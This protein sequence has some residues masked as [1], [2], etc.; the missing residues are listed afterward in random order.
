M[1]IYKTFDFI[2]QV[3]CYLNFVQLFVLF[4]LEI[5]EKS[6]KEQKTRDCKRRGMIV[7]LNQNVYSYVTFVP[8]RKI[9]MLKYTLVF[10]K[11]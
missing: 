4:C 1:L 9:E 8:I 10:M 5:L 3:T 2:L 11:L 7:L 6:Q